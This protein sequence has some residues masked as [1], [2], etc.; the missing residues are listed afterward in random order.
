M[1]QYSFID[2]HTHSIFS[3]EKGVNNSP[4][5]LINKA[6]L[7]A[8]DGR[9]VALSITDHNNVRATNVALE[10]IKGNALES[11]ID[12]ITGAEFNSGTKSLGKFT[13][14]GK[15]KAVFGSM[16]LLGYGFDHNDEE[17]VA[18]CDLRALHVAGSNVGDQICAARNI[19]KQE[20]GIEI[21]FKYL[22]K[23]IDKAKNGVDV[24]SSFISLVKNYSTLIGEPLKEGAIIKMIGV[25]FA[26]DLKNNDMATGKA[27]LDVQDLSKMIKAAGGICVLAHPTFMT[28]KQKTIL[29]NVNALDEFIS[30]VNQKEKVIDG[31]EFFYPV[32]SNFKE[33]PQFYELAKKHDLFLTAGSDYHGFAEKHPRVIGKVFDVVVDNNESEFFFSKDIKNRV[34]YLPII[35]YIKYRETETEKQKITL[36]MDGKGEFCDDEAIEE[37]FAYRQLVKGK[38]KIKLEDRFKENMDPKKLD[39]LKAI[40]TLKIVNSLS[41]EACSKDV[42]PNRQFEIYAELRSIL[43]TKFF[44]IRAANKHFSQYNFVQSNI[45]DFKHYA[46][47]V[48]VLKSSFEK[49]SELSNEFKVENSDMI[50]A[51]TNLNVKYAHNIFHTDHIIP[52]VEVVVSVSGRSVKVKD[53]QLLSQLGLTDEDL[54]H[55]EDSYKREMRKDSAIKK[56]IKGLG[57][58]NTLYCVLLNN[59]VPIEIKCERFEELKNILNS[60]IS[61]INATI[62]NFNDVQYCK[63]HVKEFAEFKKSIE[64]IKNA[65]LKVQEMNLPFA[66]DNSKICDAFQS[67]N[68]EEIV[69]GKQK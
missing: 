51:I 48:G 28:Y 47:L 59:S 14:E 34:I 54:L 32:M 17:I 41:L 19:I 46:L 5:D 69:S 13:Y 49:L 27:K 42:T 55:S 16:H 31:M 50:K 66:S 36:N 24:Y 4:Q 3:N 61:A 35:G 25:Y 63:E 8:K 7:N 26:S 57:K 40:E 37:L 56:S 10:Y 45:D 58:I 65:A 67:M 62:I 29:H 9:R 53:E 68:L 2:M 15:R 20:T 12:Y 64:D 52:D 22:S 44:S 39:V 60:S 33:F 43:T 30:I 6:L 1:E 38:R 23:L 21:P 18:F 11:K